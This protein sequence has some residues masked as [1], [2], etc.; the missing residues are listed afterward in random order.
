MTR[1]VATLSFV[2]VTSDKVNSVQVAY[3]KTELYQLG[4]RKYEKCMPDILI[5]IFAIFATYRHLNEKPSWKL[6]SNRCQNHTKSNLGTKGTSN[7]DLEYLLA[8]LWKMWIFK[9]AV[10]R[11]RIKKKTLK[12]NPRWAGTPIRVSPKL[13]LLPQ[14]LVAV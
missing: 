7:F 2:M 1:H 6:A 9:V 5:C 8:M 14:D 3:L 11:P 4:C 12:N 13:P 10:G